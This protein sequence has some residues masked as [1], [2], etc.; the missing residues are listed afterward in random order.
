MNAISYLYLLPTA[1]ELCVAGTSAYLR[2]LSQKV[3][4][5]NLT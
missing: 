4:S 5:G 1:K 2:H 3:P